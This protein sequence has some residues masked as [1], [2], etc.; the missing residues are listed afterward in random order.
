[1]EESHKPLYQL[2]MDKYKIPRHKVYK[3][4]KEIYGELNPP[5][6]LGPYKG[7]LD[8]NMFL[9]ESQENWKDKT[10]KAMITTI[11]YIIIALLAFFAIYEIAKTREETPAYKYHY[12]DNDNLV[13]CIGDDCMELKCSKYGFKLIK[14]DKVEKYITP[15]EKYDWTAYDGADDQ[16]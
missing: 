16:R 14:K 1:M 3:K 4:Q 11:L 9:H 2:I 12:N 8:Q 6:R 15:C 5:K 7:T 13:R 10:N